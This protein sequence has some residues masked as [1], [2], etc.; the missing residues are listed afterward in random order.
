MTMPAISAV[1]LTMNE[2]RNIA[3]CITSLQG[4]ADEILVVDSFSVDRT[5]EIALSM[6]ATFVE[7]AFEGYIEQ[8]NYAKMLAQHDLILS[9]DADEALDA[10][11]RD[12]ILNVKNNLSADGYFVNRLTNYC[13]QWIHHCGWHPDWKMRLFDRRKGQWAGQNPHDRYDLQ[14]GSK[15]ERLPGKLLHYS[16]YTVQEHVLQI[17]KFSTIAAQAA[18]EHGERA[19]GLQLLYKPLA[20]FIKGYFLRLGFLDGYK[21][22][23][24]CWYSGEAKYMKYK[25]LLRLQ[26]Q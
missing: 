11:L 18:F 26:H 16:Y 3:R 6:G 24:V 8:K 23:L 19:N 1:I 15:S 20:K 21:G 14:R 12:S 22:L 4:V 10:Q 25:K 17:D 2:E 7:H 13:G 5:K 9:L